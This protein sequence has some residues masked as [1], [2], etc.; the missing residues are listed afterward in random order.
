M[1]ML[2]D[3]HALPAFPALTDTKGAGPSA[4]CGAIDTPLPIVGQIN[5]GGQLTADV[6]SG[7][8]AKSLHPGFADEEKGSF[9]N[10][11]NE[12][13]DLDVKLI[14]RNIPELSSQT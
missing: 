6:P 12:S 8:K 7:T 14:H 9:R 11:K 10:S 4:S 2:S 13:G 1:A 3:Q 5:G